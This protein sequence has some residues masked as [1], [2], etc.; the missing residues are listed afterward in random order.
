MQYSI[1]MWIFDVLFG[2]VSNSF[3][4]NIFLIYFLIFSYLYYKRLFKIIY[5]IFIVHVDHSYLAVTNIF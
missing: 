4:F 5:Y 2:I 3:A 1:K